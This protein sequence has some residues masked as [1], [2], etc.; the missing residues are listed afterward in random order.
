[1]GFQLVAEPD[2]ALYEE[3]N[4]SFDRVRATPAYQRLIAAA[5]EGELTRDEAFAEFRKLLAK[6]RD[7]VARHKV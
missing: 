6:D 4:R 2:E 1:L 5:Q 7:D 3:L